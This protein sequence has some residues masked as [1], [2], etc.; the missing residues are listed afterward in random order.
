MNRLFFSIII[1]F[2]S[3]SLLSCASPLQK[4]EPGTIDSDGMVVVPKGWFY[5]GYD[6]GEFNEVPE[7]DVF[8][9]TYRIDRFEVPAK[10]FAAFLNEKGNPEDRYFSCDQYATIICLNKEGK[11][12]DSL[13]GEDI[14]R[15]EPRSGHENFPA[16]NVSWYGAESFCR[17]KGKRLPTEAEWEKAA[18]GDD[19]R[20]Y[21]WG[22]RLP[23]DLNSRYNAEWKEKGLDVLLPVDALPEGLSSYGLYHMAGNVREWIND[24]YRQNYCDFCDPNSADYIASASEILGLHDTAADDLQNNPDV[25]P[26]YNTEG[27][28]IGSFKVL[29]GGSWDDKSDRWIRSSYRFWLDPLERYG[30]TGFR[31]ADDEESVE[32]PKGL[33]EK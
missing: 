15:F 10:E 16:N 28:S 11:Q 5:M 25:P 3:L 31:C 4:V 30:H 7:H 21:P 20:L 32:Q 33:R 26:R 19:R 12:V 6:E 27:P 29:R 8:L 2:F 1:V 14:V 22:D 18:R 17:W 24:W 23:N 9:E 13:S